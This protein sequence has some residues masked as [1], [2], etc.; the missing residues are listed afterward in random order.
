MSTLKKWW[1]AVAY[2]FWK[3]VFWW[4]KKTGFMDL[5]KDIEVTGT[6]LWT[7]AGINAD[8]DFCM[9]VKLDPEFAWANHAFGRQTSEDPSHY[10]DTLHCEIVPWTSAQFA[11]VEKKIKA[12]VRVRVAGRWGFD[13]VHTDRPEWQEVFYALWRH[14]PNVLEGW[15]EI[16][17]VTKLEVLE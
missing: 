13:G 14:Q 7:D 11:A 12:G 8:G 6:V 17:P 9:N 5:G 4:K 1:L 2:A 16:H 10:P 15:C 3:M